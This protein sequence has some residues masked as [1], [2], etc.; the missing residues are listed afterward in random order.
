VEKVDEEPPFEAFGRRLHASKLG[1]ATE[2]GGK[3]LGTEQELLC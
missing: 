3:R 1:A 2:N